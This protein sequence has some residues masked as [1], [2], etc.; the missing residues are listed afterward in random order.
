MKHKSEDYKVSA[1]KY[2]LKYEVSMDDVCEIYG[3]SKTSLKRWIDRYEKDVLRCGIEMRILRG[4][5]IKLLIMPFTVK[6]DLNICVV[7]PLAV[8]PPR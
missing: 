1:V 2:Y 6:S 7:Q 8:V 5:F 4:I 3:C